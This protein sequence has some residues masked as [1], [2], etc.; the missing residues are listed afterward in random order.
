M[1]TDRIGSVDMPER[2]GELPE[3]TVAEHHGV[4]LLTWSGPGLLAD[5]RPRSPSRDGKPWRVT[6]GYHAVAV[7]EVPFVTEAGN[8]ASS[9]QGWRRHL[10]ELLRDGLRLLAGLH[11]PD[12]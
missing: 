9:S 7:A 4:P 5:H 3:R 11:Q 12:L 2:V 10:E 1:I 6:P 8:E